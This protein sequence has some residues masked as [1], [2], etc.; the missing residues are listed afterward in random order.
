[1]VFQCA[2]NALISG[3]KQRNINIFWRGNFVHHFPA[4]QVRVSRFYQSCFPLLLL[5]L[6]RSLGR[7]PRA[8]DLRGHCR[9]STAAMSEYMPW[10]RGSLEVKY[11]FTWAAFKTLCHPVSSL[12][13]GC[14]LGIPGENGWWTFSQYLKDSIAVFTTVVTRN[15]I[16]CFNRGPPDAASPQ[17]VGTTKEKNKPC[18][19]HEMLIP[20]PPK[21]APTWDSERGLTTWITMVGTRR[22]PIDWNHEKGENCITARGFEPKGVKLRTNSRLGI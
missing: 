18:P 5:L 17:A 14:L 2:S 13:A 4:C 7:Q 9:T 3:L 6:P 20:R 16:N 8:P 12:Y 19:V 11:S 1:M 15:L 21:K 10:W 22:F